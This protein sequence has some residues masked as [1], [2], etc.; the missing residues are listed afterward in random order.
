MV[1]KAKFKCTSITKF[2][3]GNESVS[4]TPV[5]GGSDENKTWSEFTPSGKLEM[6]ITAKGAV[7][8]FVPGEEYYLDITPAKKV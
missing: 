3:G 4:L 5:Y 6:M 8:Q 1:I 7:G 2:E